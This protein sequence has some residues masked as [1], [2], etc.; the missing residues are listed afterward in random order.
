MSSV[1]SPQSQA[2]MAPVTPGMSV[3]YR[4]DLCPDKEVPNKMTST[5][6]EQDERPYLRGWYDSDIARSLRLHIKAADTP[7]S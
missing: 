6:N 1:D 4:A 3:S 2:H 7:S 5:R